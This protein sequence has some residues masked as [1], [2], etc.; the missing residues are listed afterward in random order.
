MHV[1]MYFTQE[2]TKSPP[3]RRR[4]HQELTNISQIYVKIRHEPYFK[5][6]NCAVPNATWDYENCATEQCTDGL[7]SRLTSNHQI[8]IIIITIIR[9]VA[10]SD[11]EVLQCQGQIRRNLCTYPWL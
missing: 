5:S 1:D 7:H 11:C 8:M 2:S 10:L 3:I 6:L 9:V 4:I